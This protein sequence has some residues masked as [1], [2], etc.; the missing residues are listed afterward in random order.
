MSGRTEQEVFDAVVELVRRGEYLDE[1]LGPADLAA[2]EEAELL[3]GSAL[4]ELLRKLYL[5]VATGGFGPGY[6]ILG[7]QGGHTVLPDGHSIDHLYRMR[8][9]QLSP[10]PSLFPVCDWGCAILSLVDCADPQARMW[11]F[12]PN[13]V[14]DIADAFFPQELHLTEWLSLWIDG[15]LYQP[16]ALEDPI[17]GQ[18]RGATNAESAAMFEET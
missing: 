17:T 2:V 4:P 13:P 12:D 1:L 3:V 10:L 5:E 8:T 16:W 7:L 9:E 6:G 14:D 11:G 15:H 18:W